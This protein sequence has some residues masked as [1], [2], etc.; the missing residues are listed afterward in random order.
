VLPEVQKSVQEHTF[1]VMTIRA[2]IAVVPLL[3]SCA[4]SGLYY[5]SD[6]WCARHVDASAARC[7]E[8]RA[9]AHQTVAASR[10]STPAPQQ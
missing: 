8:N 4:S 9:H 5:M 10:P 7:P 3:S 6:D 2:V 1:G